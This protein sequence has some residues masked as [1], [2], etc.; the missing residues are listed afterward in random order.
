MKIIH[1][2]L[3]IYSVRGVPPKFG[4]VIGSILNTIYATEFLLAFN[5]AIYMSA[6]KWL[7]EQ[8]AVGIYHNILSPIWVCVHAEVIYVRTMYVFICLAKN[9][10]YF[11]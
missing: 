4:R 5:M 7:F 8:L 2:L 11:Y 3:A 10:W 1:K 9:I 6:G